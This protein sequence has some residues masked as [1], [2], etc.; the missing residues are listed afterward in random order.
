MASETQPVRD[1]SQRDPAPGLPASRVWAVA[2]A[3]ATVLGVLF[4]AQEVSQRVVRDQPAAV[5]ESLARGLLPWYA[6]ALL[7]PAV[8]MLCER[9]PIRAERLWRTLPLYALA[10]A[11]AA[12][13]HALILVVPTAW[14]N[15]ELAV[16]V[17]LWVSYQFI[18]VNRAVPPFVNFCFLVA[19]IH[20]V[21][22]HR[23]LRDRELTAARLAGRLSEAE[24]LALKSQ[25][26]PHFLFNTLNAIAAYVRD[27][28]EIAETMLA[29]L[30]ALLRLVLESSGQ[31]EVA[32]EREL[33]VARHYLAI[34]EVRFGGRLSV[35]FDVD[36]GL[37]AMMVPAMLLQPL[38]EN[39]VVHGV[40]AVPG[41]GR[42][43]VDARRRGGR[44]V[45]SVHNRSEARVMPG[46]TRGSGLGLANTRARLEQLYGAAHRLELVTGE[47]GAA[48]ELEI[49][50]RPGVVEAAP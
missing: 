36:P 29:R 2:F 18:L 7:A 25:L 39:A 10:G 1:A 30:S 17:P 23:R 22:Y 41:P 26:Q 43:D 45:V 12:A 21:L 32:F 31:Q 8:V 47:H 15:G 35:G 34:H 27:E 11:A 5:L 44:L 19:V 28:P 13:V 42:V 46:R 49:P 20:A 9:L 40:A 33:E 50:L 3:A 6:W 37:E 4:A 38:V 14:L 24:L 16:G 48:V